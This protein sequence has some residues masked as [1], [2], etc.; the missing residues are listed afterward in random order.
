MKYADARLKIKSGDLLAW[1]HKSW[2]TWK[3]IKIQLVRMFTRSEYSH[4]GIARVSGER[5]FVLEAVMPAVRE[6][7]LSLEGDFYWLPMKAKW[8][9]KVDEVA[10][11]KIGYPYSQIR[12]MEAFFVSLDVNDVSE[13]AAYALCV[14][15]A[16]G[17]NLGNRATPDAVVLAAQ[18]R[19]SEMFY[20]TNESK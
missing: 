11:S 14:L 19:G 7:P 5:L 3:D 2:A 6:Q 1:S 13:C 20:I 18:M 12:A 16:A 17:I 8:T 4:V 10:M 9:P 15:K